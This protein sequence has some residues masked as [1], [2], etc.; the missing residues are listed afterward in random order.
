MVLRG[1]APRSGLA[2]TTHELDQVL[3]RLVGREADALEKEV[4]ARRGVYRTRACYDREM[5]SFAR[6]R[7]FAIVLGGLCACHAPQSAPH[8]PSSAAGGSAASAHEIEMSPSVRPRTAPYDVENYVIAVDL[9]PAQRTID[10]T[11]TV[12]LWPLVPK[13]AHVDLDFVGMD[14][15]SVRDRAGHDLHWQRVDGSL[16]VDLASP[17]AQGTFEELTVAYHGHP[18]RGLWFTDERDGSPH[19][20]FTQ[21]E[22]QDARAWFPCFD[23]P[24][25]RA[26][27]E[28]RV[29]MPRA[30]TSLAAGDRVARVENGQRATETWRMNFPHPAYLET[31]VAGDLL[32]ETDVWDGIPLVYAAD[33]RF[34][35]SLRPAFAETGA[36]LEYFSAVTGVRYPY[37][38]YSQVCVDNFPFGGM[39]NISATTMTDTMLPDERSL[40]D[41]HTYGL[42]AHEAAH[43]WF[44]DYVTCHDWSQAWL[45]EG[46]A[47]YFGAL[48]TEK[49]RGLE[50]FRR[51]MR[52]NRASYLARDKGKN[53]RPIVY[54]VAR[55]PFEL[56]FSGHVYQG[57]AVCLNY[58]RTVLGDD[59]FFRGVRKY[60]ADHR[61]QSVVTDDLCIA[62]ESA[63][64]SDLR[65]FFDQWL[66]RAGL[67]SVKSHWSPDPEKRTVELVLEQTQADVGVP[68]VFRLPMDVEIKSQASTRIERIVMDQRRQ[69]FTFHCDIPLEWVRVDPFDAVPMRLDEDMPVACWVAMAERAEDS[70]G[71]MRALALLDASVK[72]SN[73]E[74]GGSPTVPERVIASLRPTKNASAD[75]RILLLRLHHRLATSILRDVSSA[76]D[77]GDL[78]KAASDDPD[79]D[80][81]V[82]AFEMLC[83]YSADP[84][85]DR[86]AREETKHVE[87]TRLRGALADLIAKFE[88]DAAFDWLS[89]ELAES[90]V[91]GA[92]EARILGKLALTHDP[93]TRDILDAWARDET[94]PDEARVVAVR[95]LGGIKNDARACDALCS[96][97]ESPR[98]RVRRAAI[99]SIA[100]SRDPR[101]RTALEKFRDATSVDIERRA[102]E[103]ALA[104]LADGS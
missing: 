31:L 80:V 85:L 65:W 77:R 66:F 41:L 92:Y 9:D 32:V 54:G 93:R 14:V 20:V 74:K 73:T 91:H 12:R 69:S 7:L 75:E 102:A 51:E 21:G 100:A 17:L 56:F 101:A 28:V 83:D 36:I 18:E 39:E 25:E 11:C 43:Q 59:A 48:Y 81:R 45:N 33:P 29:T 49:S 70:G 53:Q 86:F 82:A 94:K 52:G 67:P 72:R 84:E 63:S 8:V 40:A 15:T 23:E 60:L 57:G 22:C 76:P 87:S 37:A 71:R 58:L 44:G 38:K 103:D 79:V 1:S 95:A 50:E 35:L 26:T 78:M 27:S 10:A 55:E 30:W 88:G 19:E 6:A 47:T 13:L 61:N 42:V 89:G 90:T 64:G 5:N 34:K 16:G 97:L 98:F 99:D 46:F 4:Q 62:M 24:A 2:L 68:S 96:L 104:R 3:E